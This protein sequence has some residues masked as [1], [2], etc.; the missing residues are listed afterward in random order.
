MATA[1]LDAKEDLLSAHRSTPSRS[2]TEEKVE[3]NVLL[4]FIKPFD[5][6]RDKLNPFISNCQSAYSLA[7]KHQKPILFKYILSQLIGRAETSCSIKEFENFDQFIDFLKQQFGER[8]HYS[9]L[10]SELQE[11]RQGQTE[12]VNQFA[13]RIETC[14]AK[15]LTEI[16]ISNPTKKKEIAGRVAAMEDLALHTFTVGLQPRL[17]QIIRCRNPDSLNAA[18]NFAVAEEK[19]L[20]S[21][22]RRMFQP[23]TGFPDRQKF[24][25]RREYQPHFNRPPV[26]HIPRN[27]NFRNVNTNDIICRY[28]KNIGHTIENC[29]KRQYNNNRNQMNPQMTSARPNNPPPTSDFNNPRRTFTVTQPDDNGVD[30]IDNHY[31]NE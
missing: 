20:P 5:G 18:I 14:L 9:H 6:S 11:C 23:Y 30:E 15:L 24:P 27:D 13:L 8:K 2:E 28:C 7:D 26:P 3:L 29:R 31:L 19:L 25:P 22:N 4:K 17:S 10:L 12:G 1:K 21:V 16:K